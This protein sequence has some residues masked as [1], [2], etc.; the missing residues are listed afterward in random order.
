L[1]LRNPPSVGFAA[2]SP[3]SEGRIAS[4]V[5]Q[6]NIKTPPIG[7]LLPNGEKVRLRGLKS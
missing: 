1:T 3:A 2:T 7:F 6:R 5:S 4:F